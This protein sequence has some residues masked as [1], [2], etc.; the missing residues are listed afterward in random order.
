M[1]QVIAS[2]G[3]EGIAPQEE[4]MTTVFAVVETATPDVALWQVRDVSGGPSR[5]AIMPVTEWYPDRLWSVGDE[6]VLLQI[7][8]GARPVVSATRPELV[9]ALFDGV[10][11]EVRSGQVRVM[12]VARAPGVRCKVAVAATEA[13]VDPVASCVGRQANRVRTVSAQLQGER[14]DIVAWHDNLE[15]YLRN[16]LAPASV[17]E[18]RIEGNEAVAVAPAHQMSA[19]VGGGGLNSQLAGQLVGLRV[20]IES[21]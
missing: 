16:A 9:E 4:T 6:A 5:E 17:G 11:P 1:S 2:L 18:I 10:S 20:T 14:I 21:A 8:D 12:G 3:I 15:V 19:A 13:G 7:G